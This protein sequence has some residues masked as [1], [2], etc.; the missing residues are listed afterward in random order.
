MSVITNSL[1]MMDTSSTITSLDADAVVY[2]NTTS[3]LTATDAQAAI[4]EL[5]GEINSLD[6]DAT[7]I[8]FTAPSASGHSTYGANTDTVQEALND[9]N[10]AMRSVVQYGTIKDNNGQYYIDSRDTYYNPCG[11]IFGNIHAY[12]V[13]AALDWVNDMTS[14]NIPLPSASKTGIYAN[15]DDVQ[16]AL[17]AIKTALDSGGGGGGGSVNATAVTFDAD[18]GCWGGA[19]AG[20]VDAALRD[21]DARVVALSGG[22][23]G[24]STDAS[25]VTFDYNKGGCWGGASTDD[26][27]EALF[28][29]DERVRNLSADDIPYN[30][31]CAGSGFDIFEHTDNVD[32]ALTAIEV[33]VHDDTDS[34]GNILSTKVTYTKPQNSIYDSGTD[35][36]AEA[37]DDV[38]T[39]IQGLTSLDISFDGDSACFGVQ[40]ITNVRSALVSLDDRLKHL[41][42]EL[43]YAKPQSSIYGSNTDTVKEA[44]DD[45]NT[46]IQALDTTDIAVPSASRTGIYANAATVQAA[47]DAIKTA[48]SSG[49]GGGG[50]SSASSVSFTKP[51]GGIY[52]SGTDT[53]Q[54]ALEDVSTKVSSLAASDI[55]YVN[56]CGGSYP[57]E[58]ET[59]H[60]ALECLQHLLLKYSEFEEETGWLWF[61]DKPIYQI[62]VEVESGTTNLFDTNELKIDDLVYMEATL[63]N[64]GGTKRWTISG[65]SG[66]FYWN[67]ATHMIVY[68][69][70]DVITTATIRYTKTSD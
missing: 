49:G 57:T 16:D 61:N 63:T 23:S 69:G 22:G 25:D 42:T 7:D 19:C 41:P 55:I 9:I 66:D 56:G 70:S 29:L 64:S 53:V 14:E 51:Q 1:T 59:V 34:D 11:G 62:S 43:S 3:G 27:E 58:V 48:I 35:T 32:E 44:L 67:T 6:L 5:S 24:G 21:L 17:D 46:V 10:D 40:N 50:S 47:L 36:V 37:L 8:A 26:V 52:E 4:D 31:A 54:E 13:Y 12:T 33:F 15:A 65:S 18:S 20:D 28:D 39:T 38:S 68:G 30:S 45:I 60:D 2:D